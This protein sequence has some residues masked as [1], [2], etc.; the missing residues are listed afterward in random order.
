MGKSD[1]V[2]RAATRAD[3]MDVARLADLAGEGIPSY[4]W[5]TVAQPGQ[6]LEYVG[7]Q[8][9]A[10][11]QANFSYRNAQLALVEGQVAGMLLAYRLPD[12]A[13]PAELAEVPE[14]IRPMIELEQRAP[15]TFYVNMLATYPRFRGQGIGTRLMERVDPLAHAAHCTHSSIEVFEQNTG[16]V[17]LYRRLGYRIV[18]RLPAVAHEC[19][20]YRGDLVLLLRAVQAGDAGLC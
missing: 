17:R 18:D 9:A 1:V 5:G 3:C 2:I 20:P 15:G 12:V 6:S 7:A 14:F 8:R 4:F 10:D 16:A 11:E 13:D 19:H